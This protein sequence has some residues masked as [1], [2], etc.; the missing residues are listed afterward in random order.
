MQTAS[1]GSAARGRCDMNTVRAPESGGVVMG[2][3]GRAADAQLRGRV[4]AAAACQ[5]H[6]ATH[7]EKFS[8]TRASHVSAGMPVSDPVPPTGARDASP[9]STAATR[10]KMSPSRNAA[11]RSACELARTFTPDAFSRNDR[12]L[13]KRQ[14]CSML[15]AV[16]TAGMHG[17]LPPSS[18]LTRRHR[19]HVRVRDPARKPGDG[20]RKAGTPVP[21]GLH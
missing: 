18:I 1:V 21:E 7:R 15:P 5:H 3:V 10:H 2:E 17:G 16:G 11:A 14:C 12:A 9:C 20:S 6:R 13:R 19:S 8:L 4:H